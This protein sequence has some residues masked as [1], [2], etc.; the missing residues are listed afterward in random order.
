[1]T[2]ND[3]RVDLVTRYGLMTRKEKERERKKRAMSLAIWQ[4][5]HWVTIHPC[6]IDGRGRIEGEK[7]GGASSG[8]TDPDGNEKKGAYV[9]HTHNTAETYF[10][11][12]V[13]RNEERM[14]AGRRENGQLL[15]RHDLLDKV[16][17]KMKF[18]LG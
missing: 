10:E 1:M 4:H 17:D 5:W 16:A 9:S 6:L 7:G 8:P 18:E 14:P 11:S 12:S 3:F 13:D 2:V 15:V